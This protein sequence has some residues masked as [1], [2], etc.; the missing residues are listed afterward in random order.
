MQKKIQGKSRMRSNFCLVWMPMKQDLNEIDHLIVAV[1]FF[2]L[3]TFF[4]LP[5]NCTGRAG[6]HVK[7]K[8]ED[9]YVPG[10]KMEFQLF[11]YV[12]YNVPSRAFFSYNN[13]PIKQTLLVIAL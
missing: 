2:S 13:Q 5:K 6:L 8:I 1:A 9:L 7:R 10:C 11:L 12:K 4:S 3:P